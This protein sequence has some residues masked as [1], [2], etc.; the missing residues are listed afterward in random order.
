MAMEK[1]RESYY[2]V[3]TM[4]EY[5]GRIADKWSVIMISDG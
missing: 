2:Q 4:R 5:E 3:R 1:S